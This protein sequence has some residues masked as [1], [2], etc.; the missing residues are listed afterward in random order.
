MVS[1]LQPLL[2]KD[3]RPKTKYGYNNFVNIGSLKDLSKEAKQKKAKITQVCWKRGCY[4]LW[5]IWRQ[6]SIHSA[7]KYFALK[8][9]IIC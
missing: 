5:Q 1:D 4:L 8:I 6:L 7:T 9:R 3:V 2:L